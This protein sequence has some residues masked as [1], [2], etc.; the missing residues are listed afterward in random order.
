[1][2]NEQQQDYLLKQIDSANAMEKA[3]ME[4]KR[5]YMREYRIV[6]RINRKLAK[7]RQEKRR[8]E[9]YIS[10]GVDEKCG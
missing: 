9:M 5:P 1:M 4:E 8:L 6:S 3:L 10:K 7:I 2:L